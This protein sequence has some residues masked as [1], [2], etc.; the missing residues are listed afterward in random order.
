MKIKKHSTS[1][2]S[3]VGMRVLLVEDEMD[4]G[5]AIKRVLTQEAYI[6]DWITDGIMAWNYIENH[7]TEYTLGIFDWLLPGI[8]GLELLKRL[9]SNNNSL[10]VLMLTAKDSLVDN[11]EGLDAGADDYLVKPFGMAEL[12]AKLGALQRRSP[13]LQPQ[14]LQ[15]GHLTLDYKSNTVCLTEAARKT[16]PISLTTKEFRFLEY[17]MRHPEQIISSHQLS[18]QLWDLE[19]ETISKVVAAQV[20]L[21]I[22]K[23]ASNGCEG[24]I[25]T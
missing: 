14:Q 3:D 17:F 13:H 1:S 7:S 4:L 8:S 11:L 24:L 12:L 6:V 21:M 20:R 22:K 5:V 19:A 16:E 15:V 2:S 23:L 25:E 10:S 9:R 18:A